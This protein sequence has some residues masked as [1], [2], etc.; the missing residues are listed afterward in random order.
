MHDAH[1][2]QQSSCKENGNTK[3]NFLVLSQRKK[4]IAT[5]FSLEANNLAFIIKI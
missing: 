3:G 1:K 2:F 5:P 4:R